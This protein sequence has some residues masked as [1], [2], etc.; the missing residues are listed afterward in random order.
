MESVNKTDKF[1][2]STKVI[3]GIILKKMPDIKITSISYEDNEAKGKILSVRGSAPSR[4]RLLLFRLALEKDINFQKIDLPISNFIK[5][6]DIQFNLT[7][8]PS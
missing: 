1:V 2:V 4:D 8:I 7:L 3:N 5:G 6:T